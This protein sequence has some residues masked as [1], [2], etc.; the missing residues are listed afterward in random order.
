MEEEEAVRGEASGQEAAE[1]AAIMVITRGAPVR[2]SPGVTLCLQAARH[3]G[4]FTILEE[5]VREV[6]REVREG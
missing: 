6:V 1:A 2:S 4:A 3:P 5:A